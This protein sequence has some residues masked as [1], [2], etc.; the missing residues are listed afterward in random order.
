MSK[1]NKEKRQAMS[2]ATLDHEVAETTPVTAVQDE[3]LVGTPQPIMHETSEDAE[4]EAAILAEQA[5]DAALNESLA[6]DVVLPDANIYE[7]HENDQQAPAEVLYPDLAE[8]P[9]ESHEEPIADASPV[10]GEVMDLPA[11]QPP[12]AE[13]VKPEPTKGEL[14]AMIERIQGE[15]AKLRSGESSSKRQ[16]ASGSKARPNVIYTLLSRPNSWH[17]TP[18]VAQIQGLL[19]DDDVI[20]K[21][22]VGGVTQLTE[23]QLFEIIEA[24]KVAGKLKTKQPAVRIFQY[25]RNELLNSNTLR[26]Q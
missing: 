25:Y 26:W 19:F 16:I 12:P 6:A 7:S 3:V 23:P 14:I 8:E 9:T 24:G 21:Y 20:A 22:T 17:S 2:T 15:L 4:F 11:E 10:V 18:Q 13:P 1:K 5:A